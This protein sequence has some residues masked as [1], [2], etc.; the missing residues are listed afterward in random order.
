MSNKT[1]QKG[2]KPQETKK[3]NVDKMEIETTTVESSSSTS[4]VAPPV[5]MDPR[6]AIFQEFE[7]NIATLTKA[8]SQHEARLTLRVLRATNRL[9]KQLTC[10]VLEQLALRYIPKNHSL[11]FKMSKYIALTKSVLKSQEDESWIKQMEEAAQKAAEE[12]AQKAAEEAKKAA[13]AAAK[14]DADKKSSDSATSTP[15]VSL[16]ATATTAESKLS[17]DK[18]SDAK[19]LD[20]ILPEVEVFLH[21]LLT[22]FLLQ[23]KMDEEAVQCVTSLIER[24]TQPNF[25]RR[26]LD[27]ISARAF[28]YYSLCFERVHKL[29]Q[30]RNNLLDLYRTACLRHDE[31]S[32][33][34]LINAILRNYLQY[35]LY[36][37]AD[38]FRLNTTFPESRSNNEHARYL[39]YLGQ[40]NSI[41]LHY[42]DAYNHLTQALRKAPQHGAL[43]FRQAANKLLVIVQLLMGDIPERSVF[44][45]NG[46]K[47]S[48]KPYFQLTK[49]VR[50]GNLVEFK[51]VM[52]Q[53]KSIFVKDK[54]FTLIVRLRHNVIKTGLRK[55]NLSYSR[56]SLADVCQKLQ[57]ESEEDAEYIVAKAIHDGVIDAVIDREHRFVF[58]KENADIYSTADP[59]TA[60]HK[61]I[62]YC[63][64]IHNGAVKALRFPPNAHKQNVVNDDDDDDFGE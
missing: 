27:L 45:Q 63:M 41:Q 8:V 16:P 53:F 26:T 44:R 28:G 49:A 5:V 4:P 47:R 29:D 18:P 7:Q 35:N 34:A 54:T 33:S 10:S 62:E 56:I 12:A 11:L 1:P 51:N 15:A 52:S 20:D 43:G 30:I 22:S 61:R 9:R 40:I 36:S 64:D 50:V 25:N 24:L 23:N 39:Y 37:H 21:L 48:L 3:E 31:P 57:L 17:T 32:Q 19:K 42:S 14:A 60:Y 6:I 2:K 58:S 13:E 59:Q 38:K 55:I 46:L